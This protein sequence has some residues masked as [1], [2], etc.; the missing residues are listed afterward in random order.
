[1]AEINYVTKEGLEK[2]HKELHDLKYVQRPFISKQIA[3]NKTFCSLA[4]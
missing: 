2:L 3:L 4:F 1:M